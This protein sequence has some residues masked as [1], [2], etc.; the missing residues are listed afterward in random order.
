MI[1]DINLINSNADSFYEFVLNYNDVS[2]KPNIMLVDEI[3]SDDG[4]SFFQIY[5]QEGNLFGLVVQFEQ[6]FETFMN[7]AQIPASE[8]FE[9]DSGDN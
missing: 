2:D 8:I 3:D 9:E 4:K 1:E 6:E 5:Y 7:I